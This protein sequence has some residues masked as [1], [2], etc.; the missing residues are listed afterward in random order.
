M[1]ERGGFYC[2]DD[3]S[4]T[5]HAGRKIAFACCEANTCTRM[6]ANGQCYA[7]FIN[8]VSNFVPK[9]W[10]EEVTAAPLLFGAAR[11]SRSSR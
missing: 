11:L 1:V 5:T 3:P 7:G 10:Y 4:A 6:H 8:P 2:E 9:D